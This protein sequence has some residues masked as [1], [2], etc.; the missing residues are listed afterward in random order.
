[1]D[2]TGETMS[3]YNENGMVLG[4]TRIS[5]MIARDKYTVD[6]NRKTRF[7][8]DDYDSD[9]VLAYRVSKPFKLGM[10]YNGRGVIPYV[11]VEANTEETDNFELHIANYYE[12]FPREGT[13]PEYVPGTEERFGKKVWL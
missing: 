11:L 3:S 7:L 12:H 5:M 1:M 2:L 8:I 9:N 4:D 6:F 10:V 13:P